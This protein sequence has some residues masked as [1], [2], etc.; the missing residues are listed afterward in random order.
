MRILVLGVTGT[1]GHATWR[2]LQDNRLYDVW[3]TLRSEHALSYFTEYS[4]AKLI[5]GVDVLNQDN[6]IRVFEK[7]RPEVVINGT[8][9]IKQLITA[10]DPIAV[11]PINAIFPHQ[12]AQICSISNARLIQ[13]STDC[14]FSGKKG[15]YVE[16]DMSD[17]EDLYGKSKFIGEICQLSHV[18]TIRTSTI[19]HELTTQYALLDWFLSQKD[20][21]KG[22]VNAIYS[23]IPTFELASVIRD[24]VLSNEKLSGL[25]HVAAKPISKYDLLQ[26]IAERYNKKINIEPDE[27]VCIDRSL[28]AGRFNEQ[29]GYLPAQWPI[30]IEKLYQ[31]RQFVGAV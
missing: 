28:C 1:I 19:G 16:S 24:Y 31:S 3:G 26:L 25:Y 10:N 17:A 23:G 18:V 20:S 30:L 14:V 12:L 29:T 6:L 27:A 13:I 15:N 2:T 5:T 21:V 7:V 11:L 22:Y 8:G 9:L 4:H